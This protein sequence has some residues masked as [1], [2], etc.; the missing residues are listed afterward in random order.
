MSDANSF[1]ATARNALRGMGVSL[2]LGVAG[3][4]VCGAAILVFGALIGRS[5][6]TGTE[7]VGHW[8]PALVQLGLL[9]GGLFGVFL[10]PIAY[11]IVVRKIGFRKALLPAFVG[12]LVGGFAG[13]A[14]GPPLAVLTGI[15]GFFIA[16]FW[17]KS[18]HSVDRS[19]E[20]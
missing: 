15:S 1:F 5:G 17:A 7:Y 13:A 6:T 4:A 3:G 19:R 8:E 14:A 2:V 10:G 11:A 9:Y 12:T 16:L 20:E 18:K